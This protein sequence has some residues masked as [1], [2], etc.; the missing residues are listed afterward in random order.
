[1]N[2][3]STSVPRHSPHVQAPHI[4][5]LKDRAVAYLRTLQN[6]MCEALEAL[7]PEARFFHDDWTREAGGGGQS[8]VLADGAFLEKGGVNFSEVYGEL[9]PE[10][11]AQLPGEGTHFWAA[12]VS[13]V[14]HPRNPYAPTAHCNYRMICKGDTVWFGGGG[15]L[16]PYYPFDEDAVTFHQAMKDACDAHHPEFYPRFKARCD[17]Y[18]Y[19]PHRKEHR[20][21]GGTFYDHLMPQSEN[22]QDLKA[23]KEDT[24]HHGL[25]QEA[26]F[27]YMQDA[28]RAFMKGYIPIVKR[29]MNTPYGERERDWQLVRRGRYVEYNLMY[30]RGTIFG[31]KTDGRIESILMSLPP[32]TGWKYNHHPDPGTPEARLMELVREPR[33]W[34]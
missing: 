3:E 9:R 5:A 33:A 26:L 12:G 22:A 23:P 15:D 20:G 11:A 13:V 14:L 19:I 6:E 2:T 32:V 34:L 31:L 10:F 29:R 17:A 1:M 24:F 25:D 27:S 8:R 7:E 28:G 30:D 4:E 21:L 16:T 18:F